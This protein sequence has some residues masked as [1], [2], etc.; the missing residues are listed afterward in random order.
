MI[1]SILLAATAAALFT[2]WMHQPDQRKYFPDQAE[3]PL[4]EINQVD[5]CVVDMLFASKMP[6]GSYR[7]GWGN[8]YGPCYLLDRYEIT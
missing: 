8:G 1:R 5:Y 6:D 4:L 2:L 3:I 7:F